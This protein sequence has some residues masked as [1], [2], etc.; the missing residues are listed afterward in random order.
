VYYIYVSLIYLVKA[1]KVSPGYQ[2]PLGTM[3]CQECRVLKGLEDKMVCQ[4]C[5]EIK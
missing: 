2:D 3:V 1:G 4:D 5:L